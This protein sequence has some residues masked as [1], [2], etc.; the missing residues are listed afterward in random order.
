MKLVPHFA[1][2][3]DSLKKIASMRESNQSAALLMR[4]Y[5][6]SWSFD[7]DWY[8]HSNPDLASA[9]P[10][11]AFPDGYSH[12]VGVGYYEGRIPIE[13][14]VDDD[15]YMAMYPDVTQG[16]LNGLVQ[17]P[18]EHFRR[19]G[20]REGRLPADPKIDAAWYGATYLGVSPHAPSDADK[21]F[22]HFVA[23]GYLNGALPRCGS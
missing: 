11:S 14:D 16:I 21:C 6:S 23:V 5:L 15:W 17:S 4:Q 1:A 19:N 10:T 9:I 22:D 7:E 13:L 8:L 3:S 2:V 12:F 18:S 20:Y